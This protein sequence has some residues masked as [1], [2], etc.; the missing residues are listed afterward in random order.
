METLP[1]ARTGGVEV[2]VFPAMNTMMYEH[3]LTARHLSVVKDVLKYRVEGPIAKGL[4][5]GDV[6]IG[7]MTEWKEIVGMVVDRYKLELK[8]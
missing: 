3:P 4:A 8:Q 2:W 1:A 6:G 7:A 5:C